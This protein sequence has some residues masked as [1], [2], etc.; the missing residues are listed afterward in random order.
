MCNIR[1]TFSAQWAEYARLKT[2]K[3]GSLYLAVQ[4]AFVR[5]TDTT[6]DA[7]ELRPWNVVRCAADAALGSLE[8]PGGTESCG[9]LPLAPL[10]DGGCERECATYKVCA[11][12]EG[13]HRQDRSPAPTGGLGGH[14]WAYLVVG[15]VDDQPGEDDRVLLVAAQRVA[16][17]AS[18]DQMHDHD[19]PRSGH[20]DCGSEH[21]LE[22]RRRERQRALLWRLSSSGPA[23]ATRWPAWCLG[24]WRGCASW[25][26]VGAAC[27]VLVPMCRCSVPAMQEKLAP[28]ERPSPEAKHPAKSL[29][30]ATTTKETTP[31]RWKDCAA[32]SPR[33]A[34]PALQSRRPLPQVNNTEREARDWRVGY[35]CLSPTL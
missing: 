33:G 4:G 23:R 7:P 2:A 24:V 6:N 25:P 19:E 13:P 27:P 11:S 22:I 15:Q 30:T 12:T 8:Q 28:K 17:L 35:R 5:N 1:A 34:A 3:P 14:T 29:I 32:S 20:V 16:L 21:P 26:G 31:A 18:R 10:A 9:A